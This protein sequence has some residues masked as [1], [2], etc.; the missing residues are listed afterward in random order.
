[1]GIDDPESFT[2]KMCLS[3]DFVRSFVSLNILDAYI[4]DN[5][6]PVFRRD[7]L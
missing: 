5:E 3:A 2:H 6:K 7:G 4:F 1:M